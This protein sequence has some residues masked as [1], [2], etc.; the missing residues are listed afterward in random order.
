MPFLLYATI[1]AVLCFVPATRI[2]GYEYAWG[3]VLFGTALGAWLTRKESLARM[4]PAWLVPLAFA[5]LNS[6]RVRNCNL[7]LGIEWYLVLALPQLALSWLAANRLGR[8]SLYYALI[9]A[10]AAHC[11]AGQIG[12]AHV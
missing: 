12:R 2:L 6:L 11:L 4:L 1:A 10:C 7:T 5:L 3:V 9:V 8:A